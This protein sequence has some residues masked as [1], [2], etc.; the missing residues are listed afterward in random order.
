MHIIGSMAQVRLHKKAS[1]SQTSAQG[2]ELGSCLL[3]HALPTTPVT[4]WTLSACHLT[5]ASMA[6]GLRHQA[7]KHKHA[8]VALPMP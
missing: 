2:C 7:D 1:C 4:S 3:K 6:A 5:S 8:A